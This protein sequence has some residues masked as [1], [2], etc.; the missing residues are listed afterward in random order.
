MEER[1]RARYGER[2]GANMLSERATLPD[3]P[4]VHNLGALLTPS[5][6]VLMKVSLRRHSY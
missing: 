3:S 6:R 4:P 1:H 2:V 5:F